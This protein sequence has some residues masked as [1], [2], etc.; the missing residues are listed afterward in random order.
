[1][2][3]VLKRLWDSTEALYERFELDAPIG[4]RRLKFF[5][6]VDEFL[7][8]V[9][10]QSWGDANYMAI[11]EEA[12][13]VFVTTIGILQKCGIRLEDLIAQAEHV[14]SKNDAK[15]H[16]THEIRDGLIA[17]KQVQP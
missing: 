7:W 6:E 2:T 17:R 13:D 5:E 4:D 16:E 10:A 9:R 8:E 3:D 14:A 1:M 15:T 12:T 11:A